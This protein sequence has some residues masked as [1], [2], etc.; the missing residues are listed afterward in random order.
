[1]YTLE[2][3]SLS[4]ENGFRDV[5]QLKQFLKGPPL[6]FPLFFNTCSKFIILVVYL[7]VLPSVLCFIFPKDF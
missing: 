2:K 5:L 3:R 1:M 6:F 4:E 7:H